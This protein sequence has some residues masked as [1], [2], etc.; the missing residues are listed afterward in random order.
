[1]VI[2]KVRKRDGSVVGFDSSKITNAI[3]KAML[4]VSEKDSRASKTLTQDIIHELNSIQNSFFEGIPSVEQIQD[5]VDEIL[6]KKPI[7]VKS[8]YETDSEEF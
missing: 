5:K 7:S 1:M 8:Y 6:S 3:E 2:S 4:Y